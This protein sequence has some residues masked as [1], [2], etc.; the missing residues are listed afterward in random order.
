VSRRAL[1]AAVAIARADGL[2][3]DAPVVLRDA[4]NLLVHLAPAPV[5]ARVMTVTATVRDGA[6]WLA[7]EVAIARHL[8]AAGAPVVAPS[9]EIDPGPHRHDGFTASFWTYVDEA[10]RRLD[11]REAGRRLRTCHDALTTYDGELRELPALD[12]ALAQLGPLAASGAL[13]E[14]DAA[15]LR[16]AGERAR[17]RIDELAL[18]RQPIHGDA[19]LSNVIAGPDGPLWNDWEDAFRGPRA[20]DLG[21]MHAAARAFGGDPDAVAAAQD[22]YGE[23]PADG[24]LDAFV[25]ARRLQG[26]IWIAIMAAQRPDRRERAAALLGYYRERG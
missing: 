12:E 25:E 3:C 4:S 9:G 19:H 16:E 2:R 6:A 21:C 22:G 14:D 10:G 5:V 7:R 8:V 20:W 1:D 11:A 26:T 15:L 13:A 23:T 18:A 24:V 17:G